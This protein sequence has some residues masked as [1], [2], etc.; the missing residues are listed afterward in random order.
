MIYIEIVYSRS[1]KFWSS[2]ILL[3]LYMQYEIL[4]DDGFRRLG[5]IAIVEAYS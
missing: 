2:P 4:L 3:Y 5:F 1:P